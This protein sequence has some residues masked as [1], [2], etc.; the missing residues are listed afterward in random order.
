[1][2]KQWMGSLAI[3]IFWASAA[4]GCVAPA[5]TDDEAADDALPG[6]E[7]VGETEQAYTASPNGPICTIGASKTSGPPPLST[8]LAAQCSDPN[9]DAVTAYYFTCGN[10]GSYFG[11]NSSFTC[12]YSSVGSYSACVQAMDATGAWSQQRCTAITVTSSVQAVIEAYAVDSSPTKCVDV[13]ADGS[14][15]YSNGGTITSYQWNIG[16]V[17]YSGATASRYVCAF[18]GPMSVSLTVTNSL[19]N[20]STKSQTIN[21][22]PKF[23]R[24]KGICGGPIYDL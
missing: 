14:D 23:Y 8:T 21:I 18:Y 9:G 4:A 24:D 10:G 5:S 13:H 19:G 1:M 2:K 7:A 17:S 16:G 20:T 12:S 11:P 3:A 15:S 6:D 22:C